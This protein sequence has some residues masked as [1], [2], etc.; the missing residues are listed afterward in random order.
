V[1]RHASVQTLALYREGVMSSRQATRVA[2]HLAICPACAEVEAQLARVTVLLG[3]VGVPPM[4]GH[5]AD[6]IELALAK[7]HTERGA[8]AARHVSAKQASASPGGTA[9]DVDPPDAPE[10]SSRKSWRIRLPDLSSPRLVRGLAAAMGAVL[11]LGGVG[12]VIASRITPHAVRSGSATAPSRLDHTA[13][14]PPLRQGAA[15]S[16]TTRLNY[17]QNG[18]SVVYAAMVSKENFTPANLVRKI[19]LHLKTVD[20]TGIRSAPA[21]PSPTAGPLGTAQLGKFGGIAISQLSACL[22]KIASGRH[23]VLAV[24]ARYQGK[25]ATIIVLRPQSGGSS[26]FDVIVVGT[27][28]SASDEHVIA[29]TTVPSG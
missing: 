7:E 6:R 24:V 26:F 4:P 16:G 25:P 1:A 3:H 2:E 19:R 13:S 15:S 27:A 29:Q 20:M 21:V 28:C 8:S 10:Q 17:P 9:R 14:M 22:S 5:V 12:Y 11:L 23:V 18:I